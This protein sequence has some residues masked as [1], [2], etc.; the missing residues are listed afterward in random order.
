M[1]AFR[2]DLFGS[3]DVYLCG[4]FICEVGYHYPFPHQSTCLSNIGITWLN[5]HNLLGKHCTGVIYNTFNV[6][7]IY[8]LPHGFSWVLLQYI[9]L[10][11]SIKTILC[12]NSGSEVL[13][14]SKTWSKS[15]ESRSCFFC[16]GVLDSIPIGGKLFT[17]FILHF[18]MKQYK[19]ARSANFVELRKTRIDKEK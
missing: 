11:L 5:I 15:K 12:H 17:E 10:R 6:R 9:K 8:Q 19:N 7:L 4:N 14:I 16:P 1:T 3:C 18:T 2:D 13:M